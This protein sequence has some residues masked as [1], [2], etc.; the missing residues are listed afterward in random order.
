MALLFEKLFQSFK[1]QTYCFLVF[2]NSTIRFQTPLFSS[3][4]TIT[5]NNGNR[6]FSPD[7]LAVVSKL[8]QNI[9]A[10]NKYYLSSE[11]NQYE[12][13]EKTRFFMEQE[14]GTLEEM[15]REYRTSKTELDKILGTRGNLKGITHSG[16]SSFLEGLLGE[17]KKVAIGLGQFIEEGIYFFCGIF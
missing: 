10:R 13:L 17:T 14:L 5:E 15:L 12:K 8:L 16:L 1:L 3:P 9:D 11:A 7:L 6:W 2:H 4:Q